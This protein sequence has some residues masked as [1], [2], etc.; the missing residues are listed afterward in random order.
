MTPPKVIIPLGGYLFITSMGILRDAGG[1]WFSMKRVLTALVSLAV[2]MILVSNVSAF[3]PVT[4]HNG[5]E[6]AIFGHTFDEE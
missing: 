6:E 2:S 5:D 4:W 1:V 3:P